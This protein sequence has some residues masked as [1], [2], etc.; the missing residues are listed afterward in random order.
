MANTYTNYKV[1]LTTSELT[2]LYTVGS[3]TTAIIKSVRVSNTDEE[4]DCKIS[5]YLVDT[6]SVSYNLQT[7]RTV[8]SKKSAELLATGVSNAGFG[9]TDSSFSPA[10]PLVAKESEVIKVQAQ[11]GG[12]L[13]VI[14][15]VMEIT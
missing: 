2:T 5:L 9:S 8:K 4:N 14:L 12:D 13:H 6:S 10:I 3:E 7:D 15:S 11:N 1:I